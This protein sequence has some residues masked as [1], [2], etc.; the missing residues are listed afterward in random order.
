MVYFDFKTLIHPFSCC[1]YQQ[2]I[3]QDLADERLVWW[4]VSVGGGGSYI[5]ATNIS[6]EVGPD[7]R[8]QQTFSLIFTF[9]MHLLIRSLSK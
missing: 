4:G 5:A 3:K 9:S 1:L 2:G 8:V 7:K 6:W